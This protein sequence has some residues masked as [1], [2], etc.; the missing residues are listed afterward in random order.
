MGSTSDEIE[1]SNSEDG[2]KLKF[3][4]S[5]GGKILP[6][7]GNDHLSYV[8][9]ET[10]MVAVN[11]NITFKELMSQL[12]NLCGFSARLKYK[13]PNEDLDML[14]SVTDDDDLHYMMDEQEKYNS[15]F[16]KGSN[17]HYLKTFLF[18]VNN[19]V[20]NWNPTG[21]RQTLEQRYIDAV[22]G[23]HV[24]KNFSSE[25]TMATYRAKSSLEKLMVDSETRI[26]Q[27]V[28]SSPNLGY[29]SPKRPVNLYQS[30]PALY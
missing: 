23:I 18:P 28:Q 27:R 3:L 5:Y 6:R 14:V 2:C 17:N 9:G 4:C 8:H 19:V 13:L 15:R 26:L 10:R 20:Y 22:N 25:G 24:S 7:P 12:Q 29:V 30:R 1:S 16:S 21:S 11:R